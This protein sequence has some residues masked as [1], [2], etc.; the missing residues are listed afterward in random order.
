MTKGSVLMITGIE[1][2][3][4]TSVLNYQL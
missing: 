3:N 4:E 2:E 1:I